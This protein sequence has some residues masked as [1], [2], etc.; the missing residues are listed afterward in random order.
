MTTMCGR[1]NLWRNDSYGVGELTCGRNDRIPFQDSSVF[2]PFFTVY[3]NN[4]A[5][6][7]YY[8]MSANDS[9][10]GD[11]MQPSKSNGF[12]KYLRFMIISTSRHKSRWELNNSIFVIISEDDSKSSCDTA[13]DD[14]DD[15]LTR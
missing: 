5:V 14:V 12:K 8:T 1:I 11:E 7:L 10:N 6:F 15:S 3:K 13:D 2:V 4:D 9:D